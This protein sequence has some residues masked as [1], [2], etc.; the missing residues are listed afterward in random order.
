MQMK[1]KDFAQHARE[2]ID[3]A[4]HLNGQSNEILTPSFFFII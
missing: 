4:Q 3:F 2:H 1:N